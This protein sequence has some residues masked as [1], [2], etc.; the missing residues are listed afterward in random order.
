MKNAVALSFTYLK[1]AVVLSLIL[2][3]EIAIEVWLFRLNLFAGCV[4]LLFWPSLI[5][6]TSAFRF[7][8]IFYKVENPVKYDDENETETDTEA[9]A[10]AEADAETESASE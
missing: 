10:D 6:Y 1:D 5:F 8:V 2:L 3:L 7:A 4:S 9:D